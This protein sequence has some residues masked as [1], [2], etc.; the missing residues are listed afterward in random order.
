[1]FPTIIRSF[2]L[3][4]VFIFLLGPSV[5][6][7]QGLA[8][9]FGEGDYEECARTAS[10]ELASGKPSIYHYDTDNPAVA[11]DDTVEA[12]MEALFG[13]ALGDVMAPA[14]LVDLHYHP[15]LFDILVPLNQRQDIAFQRTFGVPFRLFGPHYPEY[16]PQVMDENFK[17]CCVREGEEMLDTNWI[18]LL[19]P[20]GDGWT[21]LWE[22]Y[23]PTTV[24]EWSNQSSESAIV[25]HEAFKRAIT[26]S[27][28]LLRG[29]KAAELV[30]R[31]IGHLSDLA[32]PN[33]PPSDKGIKLEEGEV[34]KLA[35][36]IGQKLDEPVEGEVKGRNFSEDISM[37]GGVTVRPYLPMMSDVNRR[38]LAQF[39]CMHPDQFMKLYDANPR[40]NP[41]QR[42]PPG[43]L[44]SGE[45]GITK[46]IPPFGSAHANG[47]SLL[48]DHTELAGI[49]NV[50]QLLAVVDSGILDFIGAPTDIK[51]GY[52]MWK[53][54][55]LAREA[56]L[57]N[58]NGAG[59]FRDYPNPGEGSLG[60]KL[61][62][63]L[64]AQ[65]AQSKS[66]QE[67]GYTF[68]P[69]NNIWWIPALMR[70]HKSPI[71]RR[72]FNT[73]PLAWRVVAGQYQRQGV[74]TYF[75][76]FEPN[77]HYTWRAR[78]PSYTGA[79]NELRIRCN[80]LLTHLT[81]TKLTPDRL[82]MAR[83]DAITVGAGG[84]QI[85][86]HPFVQEPQDAS[87]RQ[88]NMRSQ[89]TGDPSAGIKAGDTP[90]K[91]RK[92]IYRFNFAANMTIHRTCPK[93]WRRWKPI[94]HSPDDIGAILAKN[95]LICPNEKIW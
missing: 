48:L 25:P 49:T 33:G 81:M 55:M 43:A 17:L 34:L 19:H 18:T 83:K 15:Q 39:F 87:M 86:A 45:Y 90:N 14:A 60:N 29:Q 54:D 63:V 40:E 50:A 21:G 80:R 89:V 66:Q 82:L 88:Q 2:F 7:A 95:P 76:N 38:R 75:P 70:Y 94:L 52:E 37:V 47:L 71:D 79:E 41:Y 92:G 56:H 24:T 61:R 10:E 36:E 12:L 20:S 78:V 51:T 57:A 16:L 44:P 22:Y 32:I 58:G 4:Q 53:A 62:E 11:D 35:Q 23:F 93:G 28:Q 42:V 8:P 73:T 65:G 31:S 5:A 85:G 67:L 64:A 6:S 30:S 74:K 59:Q 13:G 69:Q 68:D 91:C 77:P 72:E 9:T 84:E 26:E 3:S 46:Q 1:M 27:K